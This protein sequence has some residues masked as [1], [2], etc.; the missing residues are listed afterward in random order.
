MHGVDVG[1]V[2]FITAEPLSYSFAKQSKK[3]VLLV[4]AVLETAVS[5]N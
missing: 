2:R 3:Y 4:E 1:P 5:A